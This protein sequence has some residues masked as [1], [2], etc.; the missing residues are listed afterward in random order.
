MLS[1]HASSSN[2]QRP[3]GLLVVAVALALAAATATVNAAQD[4][5]QAMRAEQMSPDARDAFREGQ[6]W[7]TYVINPALQSYQ[8]DVDVDDDTVVLTGTVDS[9]VEKRLA[10]RIARQAD[11]VERIDNRIDV[12]PAAVLLVV[13]VD[14]D[15]PRLVLAAAQNREKMAMAFPTPRPGRQN[16]NGA[17]RPRLLDSRHSARHQNSSSSRNGGMGSSAAGGSRRSSR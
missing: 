5:G 14:P 17:D 9:H 11:G 1:S 7:A 8:L 6:I 13:R 12:N 15:F 16:A 4:K 10:E 2:A 3:T